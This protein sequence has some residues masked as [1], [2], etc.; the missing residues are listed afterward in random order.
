MHVG[1]LN[2]YPLAVRLAAKFTQQL[3]QIDDTIVLWLE[4]IPCVN[5]S[6]VVTPEWYVAIIANLTL[7]FWNNGIRE[8]EYWY[9]AMAWDMVDKTGIDFN[10]ARLCFPAG[11]ELTKDMLSLLKSM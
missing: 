4:H 2:V 3:P 7:P 10:T 1:Y 5:D 6:I 8:S 9:D 11:I